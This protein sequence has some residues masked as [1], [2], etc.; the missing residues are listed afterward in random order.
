[1]CIGTETGQEE[2]AESLAFI[3]KNDDV[4]MW[5]TSDLMGVNRDV[6]EYRLQVNP[7]VKPRKQKLRKMSKKSRSSE[8]EV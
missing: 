2:Q 4:F 8:V 6:I 3:D 5:S 1:V 7:S